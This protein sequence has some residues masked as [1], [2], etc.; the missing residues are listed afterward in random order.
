[1]KAIEIARNRAGARWLEGKLLCRDVP[2]L[3]GP[4][5]KGRPLGASDVRRLLTGSWDSVR[6]V[7]L[8]AGDVGE[9][10]AGRRIAEATSG[11]GTE[12]GAFAGGYWPLVAGARGLLRVDVPRLDQVNGVGGIAL[13][14]L[15]NGH[16]VDVGERVARVKVVPYA[17]P[18]AA[19]GEA[20][21]VAGDGLLSVQAFRRR[22]VAALAVESLSE[23]AAQ[24]FESALAEKLEWLGSSLD[25]VR[26][27]PDE[28]AAIAEAVASLR[29]EGAEL[30]LAAGSKT[31]DPLDPTLTA[32][33]NLGA[34]V[35]RR[36]VPV[37]PGTLLWLAW[38]GPVPVVG[39]PSCG[40]FQQATVVDVLLPRFLLDDVPD[41]AGLARLGHGGLLGEASAFRMAPYRDGTAR[42]GL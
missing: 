13:C 6:V 35:E 2:T 34:R 29:D 7:E 22:R 26:Y 28:E 25:P 1:M 11:E 17:V 42:G 3:E 5:R 33:E 9:E 32:L 31:M 23:T 10:E 8:E 27:V 38:L 4:V 15:L 18:E 37:F 24:R 30:I 36:G 21:E 20:V 16:V 41:S 40:I 39:L 14:T 19:V 12:V